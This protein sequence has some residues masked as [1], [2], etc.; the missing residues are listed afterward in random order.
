MRSSMKPWAFS[1]SL[2]VGSRGRQVV[3]KRL[4]SAARLWASVISVC[5][6]SVVAWTAPYGQFGEIT[7]LGQKW[8]SPT[9]R[10][11]KSELQKLL[12]RRVGYGKFM[13]LPIRS[14]DICLSRSTKPLKS[15]KLKIWAKTTLTR[16]RPYCDVIYSFFVIFSTYIYENSC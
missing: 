12:V 14:V 7:T 9:P 11:F 3:D 10:L 15:E 2:V 1:P 8:A 4:G 13:V 6:M 5:C 16:S